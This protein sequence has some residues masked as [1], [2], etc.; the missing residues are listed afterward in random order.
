MKKRPGADHIVAKLRQADI[1]LGKRFGCSGEQ[2]TN[3]SPPGRPRAATW[4]QTSYHL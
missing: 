4:N 1:E 2:S 3:P